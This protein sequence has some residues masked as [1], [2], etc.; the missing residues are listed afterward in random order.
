MHTWV[1][2]FFP[3]DNPQYVICVLVEGGTSGYRSAAPVFQR[4][5]DKMIAAGYVNGAV[6]GSGA[7]K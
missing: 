3:A 4:I 1:T 6:S 5:A 7:R 2:G